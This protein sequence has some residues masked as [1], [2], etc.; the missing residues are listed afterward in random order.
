MPPSPTIVWLRQ[1]LR[2]ADHPALADAAARGPVVPLFVLDDVPDDPVPAGAASR[3]WLHGSLEALGRALAAVGSPLVLRRGPAER[4]LREV[5]AE[6]GAGRVVWTRRYDPAGTAADTRI[7]AD[8]RADGFEAESFGGSLLCE[9]LTLKGREGR[10][11]KVYTAFWR[12]CAAAAADDAPLPAPDRLVPPDR[13][14]R[15]DA[16]ADWG[17]LPTAPDWAAGMRE[18]WTPGEA[19]AQRRLADFVDRALG[20]YHDDRNLPGVEGTSRLSPSLHHGEVSPRQVRHAALAAA[21]AR[22]LPGDA[23]ETFAKEIVWREFSHHL[24]I[25]FPALPSEPMDRRFAAFPWREDPAAL[26]AWRKG[27]TGYPVVDAG[28]RQLWR[29]GWMHNRV[30]MVVGSFLVKH[31]L[32]HWREGERWF[33]DTLVDWDLAANS[34]S[35]Q[36]I[37]GCGADAAPYFRVFNPV[38]QGEK[39]DP[40][41]AYVRRWVPELARLPD[42]WIHKPWAA[43]ADVLAAAGVRLGQTYPRPVVD[44]GEARARALAAFASVSGSGGR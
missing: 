24:L 8:L 29:T 39:F 2:L 14:A 40:R 3:W 15:S 38:L 7:K 18:A 16:L 1:D 36:W 21:A 30:R 31:L 17:L 22:G 20:A 25:H 33:R 4:A 43:P 9:D 37:A 10:P 6:T 32:L 34:A 42:R 27:A 5:A 28:M 44:H 12:A 23:V 35:W 26:R 13:L 11:W 41:G 19:D